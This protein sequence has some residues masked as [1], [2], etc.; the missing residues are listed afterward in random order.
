MKKFRILVLESLVSLTITGCKYTNE[1]TIKCN[2]K[3]CIYCGEDKSGGSIKGDGTNPSMEREID[4]LNETFDYCPR[5]VTIE[6]LNYTGYSK[7][8]EQLYSNHI[9]NCS[10]NH[11]PYKVELPGSD[12]TSEELDNMK[13]E[14]CGNDVS[15]YVDSCGGYM[16][17]K[18]GFIK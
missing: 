12:L 15:D 8:N 5:C 13:C 2:D 4:W 18:C 11:S 16:C 17:D 14:N 9:L 6:L 3:H 10:A 1:E 7:M